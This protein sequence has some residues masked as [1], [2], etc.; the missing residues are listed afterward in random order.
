M[1][2]FLSRKTLKL[3]QTVHFLHNMMKNSLISYDPT[4]INDPSFLGEKIELKEDISEWEYEGEISSQDEIIFSDESERD[5]EKEEVNNEE[6]KEMEAETEMRCL[7]GNGESSPDLWS[8]YDIVVSDETQKEEKKEETE[9]EEQATEVAQ[10]KEGSK[11]KILKS[12]T[13]VSRKRKIGMM[14][15]LSS[16]KKRK[17]LTSELKEIES[18]AKSNFQRGR[19]V[20]EGR[21]MKLWK[22]KDPT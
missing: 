21:G 14:D 6:L 19:T 13:S 15:I 7:E 9:E 10:E 16:P 5:E 20:R 1:K 2:G 4:F 3:P 22:R 18:T 8:E 11:E 12:I 17:S